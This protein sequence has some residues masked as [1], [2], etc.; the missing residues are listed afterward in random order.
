MSPNARRVVV[1]PCSGIGKTYGSVSREAAY[2][3]T[4]DLRPK[5]TALVALSQLVLGD[6]GARAA[7]AG[8]PAIAMDGCQL[9]CA[10]KMVRENGGAVAREF[11]VLEVYR[12]HRDFK[13]RGIAVLN[14]GGLKLAG[15]L[16]EEA[17][18]VADVLMEEGQG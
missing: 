5:T 1:V 13:P 12:L 18:A 7:V 4:E 9:A 3:L 17:A 6:P 8:A 15:A 11:T 14:E 2:Q 10:S 16:A